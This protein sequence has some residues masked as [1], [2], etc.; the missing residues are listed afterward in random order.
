MNEE[1]KIY[2]MTR[3]QIG[4][5][6]GMAGI[7]LLIA[8][9]GGWFVLSN[10]NPIDSA[11][12]PTSTPA[13]TV[14]PML[15]VSPTITPTLTPTPIPYEQLIPAGWKQ[16]KTALVEIWLPSNFRLADKKTVNTTAGFAVPELLITEIP[17]KSS[18]YN[19]LVGV[20][21]DL[22]TGDS[23]DEF[24]DAKFPSLPYQAR[25]S[26][27]RTVFVNTV[28]ARRIVVEVRINNIDFND[29]VYVI[30]DGSTVWYVEYVAQINEFFD[31]LPIFEQSIKTFRT[32]KY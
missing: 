24:L 5:L 21:Y 32:V 18:A 7:L 16:Y 11:P 13:P 9:V 26:D 14:T 12:A 15:A 25:I 6:V 10:S 2:G 17:S 28:E 8:C 27:R 31:N 19:M 20:S 23:L 29:L 30:R 22:M 4:I 1:Q 3:M